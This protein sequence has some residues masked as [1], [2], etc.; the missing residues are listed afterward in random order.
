MHAYSYAE[1]GVCGHKY[2]GVFL[3][4]LVEHEHKLVILGFCG[5]LF[6]VSVTHV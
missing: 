4:C 1:S 3:G 2:V 6:V 5:P